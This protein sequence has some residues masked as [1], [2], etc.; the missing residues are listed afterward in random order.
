MESTEPITLL[1]F[2]K[3]YKSRNEQNTIKHLVS[4]LYMLLHS[5]VGFVLRFIKYLTKNFRDLVKKNKIRF[6]KI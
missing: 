6:T 2:S 5:F 3:V 4:V 1:N